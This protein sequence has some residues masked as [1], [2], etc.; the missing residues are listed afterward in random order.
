[1]K[2]ARYV[3]QGRIEIRDE[4][5]PSLPPGGLFVRTKASGLCSGELMDWYMEHKIPHV[6]G[7]EVAGV[8]E[9]SE[10]FRFPVGTKVAPHHHAACM[11]CEQCLAGREVHCRSWRNTKLEPGGLA[12]S[13]AVPVENLKDTHLVDDLAFE[14]AALMEPMACVA[15]SI[16]SAQIKP[17]ERVAI[18]GLGSM[19]LMH[20]LCLRHQNPRGLEINSERTKWAQE[21]GLEVPETPEKGFD[22]VFVLPG[23]E[24]AINSGFD[25]CKPGGRIVL[26]APFEPGAQ[27]NLPWDRLY[28]DEISLI[29]S[30]SCGPTDTAQ[31]LQWLREGKVRAKQVVSHFIGIDELPRAYEAMKRGEILK[32]MVMFP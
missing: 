2:L 12:E 25:I 30:Y 15:K 1:M 28:F 3:G 11:E 19:G 22:V 10:D 26:F 16:R 6:L 24:G 14:D 20:M 4:A 29:P 18:V 17:G 13:F 9:Q 23:T 8:V 31:A 27:P 21:L 7:H 32:A 5:P